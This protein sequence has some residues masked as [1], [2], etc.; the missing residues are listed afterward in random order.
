LDTLSLH[1]AL[2][3]YTAVTTDENATM[4]AEEETAADAVDEAVKA[5][6]GLSVLQR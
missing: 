1:D 2:P 6:T 5:L 4:E 3:I